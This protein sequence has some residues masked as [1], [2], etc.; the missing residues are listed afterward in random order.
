M[1]LIVGLGNPGVEYEKT[2]H[3]VGFMVIDKLSEKLEAPLKEKKFNGIFFK[4]KDV[5]LA[6]P[7]TYMNNSGEFVK[8]ISEYYD[9][10]IDDIIVVYDDMDTELGKVN[11]RQK[12]SSGG[13]NGINSII[14]H[15]KTDEIKR[16]KIGIGRSN[17]AINFVLGKFSFADYQIIEKVID[18]ATEALISF[19]YNDIRYVMNNFSNK[20][21]DK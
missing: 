19:I 2:R 3:N 12:G 5:I 11:I 10:L 18:V 4:N 8:A 9:I 14:Q 16:L 1:K 17:N 6:K 7:L 20:N 15:L 21:H 13:H